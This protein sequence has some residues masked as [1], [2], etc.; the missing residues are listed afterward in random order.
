MEHIS[1]YLPKLMKKE[2]QEALK[3]LIQYLWEDEK[4]HYNER[5]TTK[6]IFLTLKKL[7]AWLEQ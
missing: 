6:H 2:E 5:R 7:K 1:K 3:E 4:R